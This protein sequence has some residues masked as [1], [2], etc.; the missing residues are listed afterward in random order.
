M[1]MLNMRYV[2]PDHL[3]DINRVAG[4]SFVRDDAD[5]LELGALVRQRELLDS[6]LIRSACPLL[7]EAA[8]WVGHFQTRARGTIGG[9][10]CHLD[11]AAELPAVAAAHDAVLTV[12]GPRGERRIAIAD[13]C[14]GYMTPNLEADEI[15]TAITIPKWPSR[16]GHAFVEFARRHGDFGIVGVACLLA[17]DDRGRIARAALALCGVDVRPVRLH[18]AE[19]ALVGEAPEANAFA[20]AAALAREVEAMSDSYYSQR[21]RRRLAGVL[22]ERAL[23]AAARANGGGRDA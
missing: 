15:L 17:L 10:L 8:H 9:S 16:H 14:R 23:A 5:R 22:T 2:Q 12:A 13:W 6:P 19:Q 18:R 21:Y 7:S 20:A 1:P 3:I 11:P 4:L